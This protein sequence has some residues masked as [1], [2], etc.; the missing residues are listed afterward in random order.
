M[1][2]KYNDR[3]PIICQKDK[4]CVD[5]PDIDKN[6]FLVPHDLTMGQ[7]SYVVRKKLHLAPEKAMFLFVGGT[8]PSTSS[9]IANVDREHS[10]EDGFLYVTYSG[11]NTFG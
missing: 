9:V 4:S 5:I 1:R 6:K 7:F 10:D 11:E 3:I 8:I 2:E